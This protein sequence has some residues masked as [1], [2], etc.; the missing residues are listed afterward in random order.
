MDK[1]KILVVDDEMDIVRLLQTTLTEQ[2]YE[3]IVAFD[4]IQAVHRAHHDKPDLIILDIIM[5]AGD[6]YTVCKKLKQSSHTWAIPIIVLT[7]KMGEEGRKEALEKG[8]D[9]YLIKPYNRKVLLSMVKEVLFSSS[10][11]EEK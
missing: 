9:F 5:P 6:G 4:G 2:G 7:G 3:V 10:E 8:V 1:K 11:P